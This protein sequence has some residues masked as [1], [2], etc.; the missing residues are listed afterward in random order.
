MRPLAGR[1]GDLLSSS[2]GS[3]SSTQAAGGQ[4]S[5]M[6]QTSTAISTVLMRQTVTN[7]P[8]LCTALFLLPKNMG[9]LFDLF[10]MLSNIKGLCWGTETVTGIQCTE[11]TAAGN[12]KSWLFEQSNMSE[13]LVIHFWHYGKGEEKK[14]TWLVQIH[15]LGICSEW[16]ILGICVFFCSQNSNCFCWVTISLG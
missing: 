9:L 16:K 1:Q 4:E 11:L 13:C 7:M 2:S 10:L 8:S 12:C 3:M 15:L 5:A 6:L 14:T